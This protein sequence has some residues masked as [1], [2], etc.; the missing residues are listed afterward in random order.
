MNIYFSG[1]G[2]V[3]IG[4]LAQIAYDAGYE[5]QG[6]DANETPLTKQ[7]EERGVPVALSQDG[8]FLQA[9]HDKKPIDWYVYTAA[10]PE[11]HPELVLARSL[12]IKTAKR[13]ELLAHIIKEKN[14]KLLAVTGTHGKTTT[15]GMLT[16]TLQQLGTPVSYSVGTTLSFG[17]SGKFEP[18]SE[19]F[20]YECD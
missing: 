8:T 11:T 3:G 19:F 7:L 14:L 16:W 20:V 10:L 4:P 1:I 17:P 12:G 18:D 13:D 6:S 15:T 9:S 2:G 5:V